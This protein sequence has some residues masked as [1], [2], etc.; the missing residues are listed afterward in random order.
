METLK[1]AIYTTPII[2]HHAHNLLVQSKLSSQDLLS[3]ASE[4]QGD[5][6]QESKSSLANI[7]AVKQLST[8]LG[9]NKTWE[10]V[11]KALQAKHQDY[12]Y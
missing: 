6:L 9:C 5:A 10:G 2:D 11:R 7:R 1:Q 3:I 8:I 12:E 4:A